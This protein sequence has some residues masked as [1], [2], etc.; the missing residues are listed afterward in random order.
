LDFLFVF[1]EKFLLEILLDL[2]FG[3]WLFP[4]FNSNSHTPQT[5]PILHTGNEGEAIVAK[6]HQWRKVRFADGVLQGDFIASC[7][8]SCGE[9]YHIAVL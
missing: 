4:Y 8:P 5:G 6:G 1:I 2:S 9:G 3:F 7:N